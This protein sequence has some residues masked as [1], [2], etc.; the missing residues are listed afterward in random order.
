MALFGLAIVL[1]LLV[2]WG[3]QQP[4]PGDAIHFR[5]L[6]ESVAQGRGLTE[7][8]GTPGTFRPPVYPIVLGSLFRTFGDHP[9]VVGVAQA[10]LDTATIALLWVTARSLFGSGVALIAL[11]LMTVA[12]AP[13]AAVRLHLSET[14]STLLLVGT[15]AAAGRSAR[16]PRWPWWTITGVTCGLLILTRGIFILWPAV[17]ASLVWIGSPEGRS[18]RMRGAAVVLLAAGLTVAPWLSR[19]QIKIGSPVLT[20]QVGITLYS[21]YVREPGQPYGVLTRDSLVAALQDL[22]PTDR[23]RRLTRATMQWIVANPFAALREVP[24]KVVYFAAP[25]DWEIIGNRA[26]NYWYVVVAPLALLGMVGALRRNPTGALLFVAPPAYLLVMACLF[27]G[28]PRLRLPSEYFLAVLAAAA[29]AHFVPSSA[30]PFR[31][32]WNRGSVETSSS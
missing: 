29:I 15:I 6:G 3:A 11:G 12:Y 4:Q 9:R 20:T 14:L 23:S 28:S 13:I 8:D 18:V 24:V 25:F 1:R 30:N 27:Y 10:L 31:N 5:A 21:S 19:N 26:L 16:S 7:E 32:A 2:G 17:I 22:P